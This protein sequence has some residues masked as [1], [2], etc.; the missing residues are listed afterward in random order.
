MVAT[1]TPEIKRMRMEA[2]KRAENRNRK[3]KKQLFRVE[4]SNSSTEAMEQRSSASK[5]RKSIVQNK[6]DYRNAKKKTCRPE[7]RPTLNKSTEPKEQK[8]RTASK[9]AKKVVQNKK[10][11]KPRPISCQPAANTYR[12][13]NWL[14]NMNNSGRPIDQQRVVVADAD[15]QS[16]MTH[17]PNNDQD[18]QRTTTDAVTTEVGPTSAVE[19][20][21]PAVEERN[22]NTKKF[23]GSRKQVRAEDMPRPT[24][25]AGIVSRSEL[26]LRRQKRVPFRY[27]Q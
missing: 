16:A 13:P 14:A 18:A 15:A 24:L 3:A 8:R 6:M 10:H 5:P 26:G 22:I 19:A 27:N 12:K 9:T 23:Y 17:L 25:S 21:Q 2:E 20:F 11:T 4:Q 7:C 1:S